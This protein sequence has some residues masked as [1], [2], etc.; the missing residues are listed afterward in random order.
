MNLM[1]GTQVDSTG[2]V[3]PMQKFEMRERSRM[4]SRTGTTSGF[5]HLRKSVIVNESKKMKV[6]IHKNRQCVLGLMMSQRQPI[7]VTGIT[8]RRLGI[9]TPCS[10]KF[11]RRTRTRHG[12]RKPNQGDSLGKKRRK[13]TAP[14]TTC[15]EI[16]PHNRQIRRMNTSYIS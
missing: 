8:Q 5:R 9:A 1:G 14:P 13:S 2:S 10:M 12:T 15:R 3:C 16:K 11:K 4:P 6:G 7:D